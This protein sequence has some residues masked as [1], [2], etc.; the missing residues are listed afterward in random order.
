MKYVV[1][2][3]CGTVFEE[4][5]EQDLVR[6]AQLHAKDKHGYALPTE[7]ILH[8]MTPTPPSGGGAQD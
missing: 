4:K 7:E 1:C 3:P 5:T 2:P 8:A 6:K